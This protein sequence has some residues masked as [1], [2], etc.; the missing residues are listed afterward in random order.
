[1]GLGARWR[2]ARVAT[3]GLAVTTVVGSGLVSGLAA[4]TR[5]AAAATGG[6][7]DV[8]AGFYPIAFAVQRVGGARVT[9][10][11]LTPVGVE[12]HDLELT[13][14]E[15]DR[16]EDADLVVVLGGGFQPA[17]EDVARRRDG[18]TLVLLDR[19]RVEGRTQDPHVW[20]DPRLMRAIVD[21]I[22]DALAD[23][24]PRGAARY[25]ANAAALGTELDALDARYREGLAD[26]DRRLVVTAHEA[27][28]HLARAYDLR[29]EGLTGI[30]P[31]AEPDPARLGELADLAREEGVT[32][33]FTEDLVSA[34][35]ARTLAREAGGLRVQVLHPL[36]GL[37]PRDLR[38]GADYVSVMDRNLVRLRRALGCR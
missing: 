8:V 21:E 25:R 35:L 32:T 20:L 1:M 38:R 31:D 6:R 33:I 28:G 3:A 27:F 26:C 22:S 5:L 18:A 16:L 9:V 23:V 30:S 17:V 4:T 24:D 34:R 14:R 11:N 12:P 37:T 13:T 36:E 2:V 19:L 29:Q 7:V 15:R 10:T